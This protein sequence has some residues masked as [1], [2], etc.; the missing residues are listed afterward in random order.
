MKGYRILIFE[1]DPDVEYK[2]KYSGKID[3]KNYS[4]FFDFTIPFK[5]NDPFSYAREESA[6]VGSGNIEN[7]GSIETGLVIEIA[8][9]V[10]NPSVTIGGKV[11][12]YTGT[13]TAGQTLTIDTLFM[14]AK[15]GTT[16]ALDDLQANLPIL[17][18]PGKTTVTAGSNATI[19]WKN[20]YL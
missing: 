1:D 19:R 5:M 14:T 7:T 12:T 18:E 3:I 17:V 8:G 13:I 11:L 20:R 16:N 4:S 2:V 6:L 9:A 10:T 15:I